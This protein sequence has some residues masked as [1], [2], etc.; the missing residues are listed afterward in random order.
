MI[1]FNEVL[2]QQIDALKKL[3]DNELIAEYNI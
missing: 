1:K 2:F 3:S